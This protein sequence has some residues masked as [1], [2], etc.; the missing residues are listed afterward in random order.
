LRICWRAVNVSD[1]TLGSSSRALGIVSVSLRSS[2][3]AAA[4]ST[5]E[6]YDLTDVEYVQ[7]AQQETGEQV[8]P[9][10]RAM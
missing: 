3:R 7:Y 5:R 2:A 1:R 6:A 10:A 8:D 4:G 9:I